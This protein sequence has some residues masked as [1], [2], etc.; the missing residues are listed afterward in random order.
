MGPRVIGDGGN[1]GVLPPNPIIHPRMHVSM[2][3]WFEC[4]KVP[5]CEIQVNY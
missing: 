3:A 1:A 4:C 2:H 5:L